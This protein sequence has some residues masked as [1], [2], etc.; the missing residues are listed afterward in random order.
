MGDLK[1]LNLQKVVLEKQKGEVV[2]AQRKAEED[3]KSDGVELEDL[4]KEKDGEIERL[5]HREE[6]MASEVE[7]LRGLVAEERLQADLSMVSVSKLQKQ[8]EE[9]TEDAKAAISMTEGALKAQPAIL[10]LNFDFSQISFFKD[11]VDGKVIDP[12]D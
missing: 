4:R 5:K 3:L 7:R 11:I 6:E 12:S 1:V 2:A 10:A 8:C 9:L